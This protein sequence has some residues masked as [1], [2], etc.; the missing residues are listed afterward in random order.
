MIIRADERPAHVGSRAAL[1]PGEE[2]A[3]A[4]PALG[5]GSTDSLADLMGSVLH[6]AGWPTLHETLT[7]IC[8]CLTEILPAVESAGVV[9]LATESLPSGRR[10]TLDG[11][12]V[13]GAAP[14]GG[15]VLRIER[16]LGEG[17]VLTAGQSQRIVT[18]GDLS[19]DERWRRF[20]S[21][22]GSLQLHS[23]VSVPLAGIDGVPV[24]VLSL[25]SH[26]RDAF[27]SSAVHLVAAIA[28]VARNALL[29][30]AMLENTRR[31]YDVMIQ[32][33]DRSRLV[34]QA[35]GVLML[36]NCTEEQ[37]RARLSRMASHNG[38]DVAASAWSIVEEARIEARL[39]YIASR[40]RSHR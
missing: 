13:V 17:P 26:Q 12:E 10:L 6:P 16:D 11:A 27:D 25:Y 20:G 2:L 38:E 21:A 3:E 33:R 7:E 32:A 31:A 40:R 14:A 28:D 9:L 37:A 23:T 8:L 5:Q 15:I 35:V 18:S 22:V 39:S 30:A 24:A 29:G 19:T 36:R 34:N 4:S 1:A